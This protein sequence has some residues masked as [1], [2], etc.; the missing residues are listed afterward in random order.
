[1]PRT[2]HRVGAALLPLLLLVIAACSAGPSERPAVAYHDGEQQIVPA[3]QPPKPAPV[4]PLGSPGDDSLN[5]E[6]CTAQTRAELGGLPPDMTFSC[7]R[8][9]STLDAPDAP[10]RGAARNALIRTGAGRVPLV[11]LGDIGGEPGTTFAARLATQLPPEMLQTFTIIGMDRRGTGESDPADCVPPAQRDAIVGFDPRATDRA[12]L[13]RLLESVLKASQECLL[14]LDERLQAYDTWRTA[15]DLEELRLELGVPKLHAIGRGEAARLLTTFAERFPGS[16]GRLVLDGAPDPTRDSIGQTESQA[17]SAEQTFDAFAADCLGRRCPLGPDPRKMVAD[18]VERT[19]STPLPAPGTTVSA[20]RVVQAIRLGLSDLATWPALANAL[21]AADRGDGAGLAAISAPLV[22]V[23]GVNPP[24]L[25]GDMITSCNDTT[26]RVPPQRSG[27][28]A[29]DW[30]NRFP[31][32]GGAAAQRVA[33][34]GSWPVPQQPL[35]APRRMDLPP[36]PVIST[37]NDPQMLGMGSEHM[38]DQLPTG[39]LLRWQ[40]AGHGAVGKSPCITESVSRF[41]VQGTVPTDGT[42]CPG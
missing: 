35:P 40:G 11:V 41:L 28:L 3:P 39:V 17:Q 7:S 32:F 16:V 36:I 27:E 19:R 15:S 37:A 29:L 25:D 8:L 30:V 12:A 24:W 6:D 34:C 5:W 4:P 42:A 26:V 18:L 10:E 22:T 38:A 20:G 33:W 2:T 31:L 9:L 21:S 23:Q 14:N 13:D 1:M